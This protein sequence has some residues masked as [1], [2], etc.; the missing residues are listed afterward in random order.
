MR[1][2]CSCRGGVVS[3]GQVCEREMRRRACCALIHGG[4]AQSPPVNLR[5]W[6]QRCPKCLVQSWN[7]RK[8]W[9][10]PTCGYQQHKYSAA[11]GLR[12]H[13]QTPLCVP[14]LVWTARVSWNLG[15][16]AQAPIPPLLFSLGSVAIPGSGSALL[17]E[18]VS[19]CRHVL[20]PAY[21]PWTVISDI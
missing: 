5:T 14:C 1:L 12:V 4:T 17:P 19:V 2:W 8:S 9:K 13:C 21:L 16:G 15:R 18:K 10:Q 3:Q 20:L 7:Y 11:S 6:V